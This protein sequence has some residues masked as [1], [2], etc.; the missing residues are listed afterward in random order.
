[1][2]YWTTLS[3]GYH[4]YVTLRSKVFP[5]VFGLGLFLELEKLPTSD[6]DVGILGKYL[7]GV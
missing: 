3:A 6:S 1:M 5:L 7:F 2:S 4:F